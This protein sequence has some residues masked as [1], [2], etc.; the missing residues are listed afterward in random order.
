MRKIN[1]V[2]RIA[3][4]VALGGAAAASALAI[5]PGTFGGFTSATS[6][7]GNSVQSGTL[8]MTNS[9]TGAA[10]VTATTPVNKDNMQPGD[11]V[12]GSVTI[13]NSGSLPA[14]M[15]LAISHAVNGFPAGSLALAVKEGSTTLYSGAVANSSAAIALGGTAWAAAEAH[16]Y[17][18]T[19]SI[20]STADNTAQGKS[21]SFDLDWSGAQR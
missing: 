9:A 14:T 15:S 16:T 2:A 20:P 13:T 10:V 7:P 3:G 11:S 4:T 18:V 1:K 19:V 6:N 21:A 12:T 5:T 17:T 8:T